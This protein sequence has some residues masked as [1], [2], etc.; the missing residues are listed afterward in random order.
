MQLEMTARQ[1]KFISSIVYCIVIF[2]A[3]WAPEPWV[4]VSMS[5]I[6]GFGLGIVVGQSL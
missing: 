1:R 6:A 5:A 3:F 4:G 2:G